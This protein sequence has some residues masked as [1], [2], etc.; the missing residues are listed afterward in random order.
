MTVYSTR[1]ELIEREIEPLLGD[2]AADFDTDA[3]FVALDE[4]GCVARTYAGL[5]LTPDTELEELTAA[6]TFGEV[7]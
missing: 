7:A 5:A 2:H 4:M 3:I 1:Q 6:L